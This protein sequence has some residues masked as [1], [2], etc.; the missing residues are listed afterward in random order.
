MVAYCKRTS[1]AC[2]HAAREHLENN[3][4]FEDSRVENIPS[5]LTSEVRGDPCFEDELLCEDSRV[6]NI[7]FRPAYLQTRACLILCGMW[8]IVCMCERCSLSELCEACWHVA[9]VVMS[10][11]V[12]SSQL[13]A[14]HARVC[15][16]CDTCD[17]R[18]CVVC[19]VEPG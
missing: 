7:S 1:L 5:P 13:S 8:L 17:G 18:L 14:R 19:G 3:S 15:V 16:E 6:E 4:S 12:G 9:V 2:L 10:G 11:V